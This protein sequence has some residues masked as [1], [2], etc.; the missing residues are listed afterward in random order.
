MNVIR[1]NK[2]FKFVRRLKWSCKGEAASN[3]R[4]ARRAS[5]AYARAALARYR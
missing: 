2:D 3:V 5:K 4:A 1:H